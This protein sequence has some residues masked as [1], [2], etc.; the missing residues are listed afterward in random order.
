VWDRTPFSVYAAAQLVF[1]DGALVFDRTRPSEQTD[2]ELGQVDVTAGTAPTAGVD[3]PSPK[4][5]SQQRRRQ[6][7]AP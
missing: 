5:V 7:A 6:G 3:S 4:P 2:F 1:I